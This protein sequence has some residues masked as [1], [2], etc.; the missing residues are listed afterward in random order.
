MTL[1]VNGNTYTGNVYDNGTQLVYTITEHDVSA[2][3]EIS[4]GLTEGYGFALTDKTTGN[5]LATA[6]ATGYAPD[7]SASTVNS[8]GFVMGVGNNFIDGG[9]RLV[10]TRQWFLY[11]GTR[12]QCSN[13]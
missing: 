6:M 1:S 7:D 11:T 8:N 2:G 12:W 13:V 9:E 5:V 10:L 3:I 4:G